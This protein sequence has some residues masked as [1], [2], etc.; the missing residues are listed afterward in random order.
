MKRLQSVP[1]WEVSRFRL[2]KVNYQ[3]CSVVCVS[4]YSH[5]FINTDND[6]Y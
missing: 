3:G 6:A 1:C 4:T 2:H 5:D